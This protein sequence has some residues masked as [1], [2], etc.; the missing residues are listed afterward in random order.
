VILQLQSSFLISKVKMKVN[1]TSLRTIVAQLLFLQS[2]LV[3]A[4]T[5]GC[6]LTEPDLISPPGSGTSAQEELRGRYYRLS[7]P[8]KYDG[9]TPSPLIIAFHDFNT[10]ASEFEELTHLSDPKYNKD[11]IVLYPEATHDVSSLD[12]PLSS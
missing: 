7:L 3:A 1:R 10:S 12:T 4:Q 8:E 5:Y 6:E 11:A 9:Q 2:S